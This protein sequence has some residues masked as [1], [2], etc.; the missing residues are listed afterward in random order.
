MENLGLMVR[1][2]LIVFYLHKFYQYASFLFSDWKEPLLCIRPY[3]KDLIDKEVK[4]S[5]E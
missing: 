5:G 2:D 3:G 4:D 1:G